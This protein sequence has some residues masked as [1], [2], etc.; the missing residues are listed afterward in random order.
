MCRYAFKNYK[1]HF[2]CFECRKQFKRPPL[3][4]LLRQSGQAS[5]FERLERYPSRALLARAERAAGVTLDKLRSDYRAT[6]SKCPQ[7]GSV[8]ADMGLDFKPPP[9]SAVRAWARI[10]GLLKVGFYWHTCGCSGPGYIPTNATDYEAYLGQRAKLFASR[11]KSA[12][13]SKSLD[14]AARAREGRHWSELLDAIVVE[15]RRANPQAAQRR[16]RKGTAR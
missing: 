11:L 6:V 13:R 1:P 3:V 14:A 5:L 12:R 10:R 15:Q 4:D 9:T 2:V 8:M 16:T 7:C